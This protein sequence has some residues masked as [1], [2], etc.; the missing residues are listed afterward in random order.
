M[1]EWEWQALEDRTEASSITI[2][3]VEVAKGS[4]V[5]LRP[6]EGADI[7]DVALR[8]RIAIIESIEQ[9]YE[10]QFQLAVVMEDDPGKDLG[11]LR[12]PGHRFFFA[13]AEVE[14]LPAPR[15]LIAGIG[16]IFLGDDGFGVEVIR[17]LDAFPSNVTVR[18]F[19]IRGYD[20]AYAVLEPYNVVIL[21]DAV[22]RGGVPGTLF[23]IE[24]QLDASVPL[25]PQPVFDAHSM[26]PLSVLRMAQNLGP[27]S[28]RLLVLGCEPA[29]LGGEHG[30]MGLSEAVSA[31]VPVAAER[32][33]A[34]V[35]S[36]IS[37]AGPETWR[38]S[39]RENADG[40]DGIGPAA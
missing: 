28:A 13:P 3:G 21:I 4:R 40:H 27:V 23:L 24:P 11:M 9:D 15:I 38:Q 37:G 32:L 6:R 16:N 8:G 39:E 17:R 2:A 20:L 14:P 18:D 35:E 7:F 31:M 25:E 12:Q 1:N 22:S 26:D 36:I 29:S 10:G 34:L 19:G 5:R 33:K 30:E